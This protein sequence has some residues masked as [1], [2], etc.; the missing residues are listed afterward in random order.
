MAGRPLFAVTNLS[1][2]KFQIHIDENEK[3]KAEKGKFMVGS[4]TRPDT[5]NGFQFLL[6]TFAIPAGM[7]VYLWALL[8]ATPWGYLAD[9]FKKDC[10]YSK[11]KPAG[12]DATVGRVRMAMIP[13][14]KMLF[15]ETE[16]RHPP[17]HLWTGSP[18]GICSSLYALERICR[19]N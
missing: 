7:L 17:G 12:A 3:L 16:R 8:A 11:L 13:T 2:T 5:T 9:K 19:G 14:Q 15:L 1:P 10:D 18:P 6:S 4:L